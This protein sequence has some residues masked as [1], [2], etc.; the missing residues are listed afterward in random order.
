MNIEDV[1][2]EC[3]SK[4]EVCR[5]LGWPIN[6]TYMRII[7]SFMEKNKIDGS[8]FND[9]FKLNRRYEV[10][11]KECPVCNKIFETKKGHKGEKTT[12][13]HGCSNTYFRSAKDNPNWK[14]NS[15]RSTCFLYHEKKCI[16]CGETNIVE[17]H[18]YDGDHT[19]NNIENLI[20]LCPT[21]HQYVHS[22]HKHFIQKKIDNYRKEFIIKNKIEY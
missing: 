19:N 10:V 20:P 16:I 4:S 7:S 22:R 3:H 18:H 2:Y 13:S 12:C 6:G 21:H 11:K 5:K 15:Y 8:I 14:N 9:R 17:V 1:I